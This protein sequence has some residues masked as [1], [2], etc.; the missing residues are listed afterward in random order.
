MFFA[1]SEP[2]MSHRASLWSWLI[3][4]LAVAALEGCEHGKFVV[5]PFI[6][7]I[8]ATDRRRESRVAEP[9]AGDRLL[10]HSATPGAQ[11][12]RCALHDWTLVRSAL[13]APSAYAR[14]GF[15]NVPLGLLIMVGFVCRSA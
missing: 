2:A 15:G 7:N 10:V 5:R 14:L 1:E 12:R 11:P 6:G 9:T 4:V 13:N 3:A 8:H